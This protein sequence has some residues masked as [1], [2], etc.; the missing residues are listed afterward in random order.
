MQYLYDNVKFSPSKTL[1]DQSH[2]PQNV[3]RRC[4]KNNLPLR[5]FFLT[6]SNVTCCM[7]N[8]LGTITALP[9]AGRAFLYGGQGRQLT[10]TTPPGAPFIASAYLAP[11]TH[12]PPVSV[13]V[14]PRFPRPRPSPL[15]T[16]GSARP[17]LLS[18]ITLM[19]L[20]G[21]ACAD[22]SPLP[23]DI[24]QAGIWLC[25]LGAEHAAPIWEH[26]VATNEENVPH[27]FAAPFF[28]PLLVGRFAA[29]PSDHVPWQNKI[30]V[31]AGCLEKG[32]VGDLHVFDLTTKSWQRWLLCTLNGTLVTFWRLGLFLCLHILAAAHTTTSGR[33]CWRRA[34]HV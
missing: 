15:L 10:E 11:H 20:A 12:N 6:C 23:I 7:L 21:G 27:T 4:E 13:S 8:I 28:F 32:G 3:T 34:W 1:P 16:L 18:V 26:I 29:C 19:S 24:D 31:H 30:F 14:G 17:Q 33:Y 22:M 5:F 25:T 2:T 9:F